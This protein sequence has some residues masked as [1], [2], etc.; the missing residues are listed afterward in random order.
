MNAIVEYR[1]TSMVLSGKV[2][3]IK[4]TNISFLNDMIRF[5]MNGIP[6]HWFPVVNTVVERINK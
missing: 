5:E 3:Y 4:A 2:M 1:V 6:M